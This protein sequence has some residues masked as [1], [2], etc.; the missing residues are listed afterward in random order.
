[1]GN[2]ASNVLAALP[3]RRGAGA[4]VAYAEVSAE[5]EIAIEP[6]RSRLT[7]TSLFEAGSL[8]KTMTA[9]LLAVMGRDGGLSLETTVGA[10]LGPEAGAAADVT[11]RQLATHTAGLPRLAP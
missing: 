6:G 1:M 2:F 5:P 4:A 10:L 11:L 9:T 7:R 8:T 3:L